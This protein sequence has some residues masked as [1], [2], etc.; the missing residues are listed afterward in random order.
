VCA[1]F[2]CEFV[3]FLD[4]VV[5]MGTPVTSQDLKEIIEGMVR[6]FQA[7]LEENSSDKTISVS[8]PSHVIQRIK[9]LHNDI[10]LEGMRNYLSWFQKA[11]LNLC[12][13]GLEKYVIGERTE[14]ENKEGAEWRMWSNTNS[15]IVS[16]LLTSVSLSI[17]GMV[18]LIS[19]ATHV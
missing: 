19:S 3:V 5:R 10:N 16:W 6:I 17:A 7:K 13:K 11:L 4:C 9:L 14:S 1:R 15:L 12:V 8:D 2:V 18:G